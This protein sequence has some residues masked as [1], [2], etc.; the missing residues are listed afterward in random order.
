MGAADRVTSAREALTAELIGDVAELLGKAEG[1]SAEINEAAEAACRS[2]Q[3]TG[4]RVGVRLAEETSRSVSA[5]SGERSAWLASARA[6]NQEIRDTAQV[7]AGHQ[8]SV[9]WTVLGV[10]VLAGV[11]GGVLAGLCVSLLF[12]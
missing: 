5:V 7:L 3:A 2:I 8:R 10:G 12:R 4:E 6:V 1:L 11:V 9:Y